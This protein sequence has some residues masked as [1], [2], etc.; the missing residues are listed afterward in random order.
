MIFSDDDVIRAVWNFSYV[1]DASLPG[2]RPVLRS[3]SGR[4]IMT[5]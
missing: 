5:A 2:R 1:H 4:A 3:A